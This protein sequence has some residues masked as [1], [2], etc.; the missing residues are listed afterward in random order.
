MAQTAPRACVPHACPPAG[1]PAFAPGLPQSELFLPNAHAWLAPVA[2]GH[3][4]T[5]E[6]SLTT[7]INNNKNTQ[8][9]CSMTPALHLPV[10]DAT[11]RVAS[12]ASPSLLYLLQ[13]RHS[14][15]P[16]A[17][18]L[19]SL[20]ASKLTAEWSKT[21][22]DPPPKQAFR[23]FDLHSTHWDCERPEAARSRTAR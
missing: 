6:I 1:S 20:A 22:G 18:C 16:K 14:A 2:W 12:P 8:V 10:A 13:V 15:P 19:N 21:P 5:S 23:I 17:P 11:S 4:P 7:P 3:N 9:G